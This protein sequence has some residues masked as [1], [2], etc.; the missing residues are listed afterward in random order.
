MTDETERAGGGMSPR[1]EEALSEKGAALE[2]DPAY[3][4]YYFRR[5]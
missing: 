2:I 3:N 1:C 5:L 4:N